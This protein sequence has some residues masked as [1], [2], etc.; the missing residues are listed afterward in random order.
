MNKTTD[1]YYRDIPHQVVSLITKIGSIHI[2]IR[3]ASIDNQKIYVLCKTY[4]N[5][6]GSF[7]Y[8][9]VFSTFIRELPFREVFK[10]GIR[11]ECAHCGKAM[12]FYNMKYNWG[13]NRMW[14]HRINK[15][16]FNH[17][18]SKECAIRFFVHSW[19]NHIVKP[20]NLLEIKEPILRYRGE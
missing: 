11:G 14:E 18:C 9:H 20:Y 2:D 17:F 16:C 19:K 5:V 15:V 3:S 1:P 6:N 12:N 4:N 13:P 10:R 8:H 7:K